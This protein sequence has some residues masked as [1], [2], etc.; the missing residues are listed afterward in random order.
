VWVS[1][2]KKYKW[3]YL[4]NFVKALISTVAAPKGG[5]LNAKFTFNGT[6]S[7]NRFCLDRD[8][9]ECLTTLVRFYTETAVL[10]FEPLQGA[11]GQHTIFILGSLESA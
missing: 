7:T 10:R 2:W 5:S 3:K 8:V 6:S 1:F 4:S 11:E 9:N